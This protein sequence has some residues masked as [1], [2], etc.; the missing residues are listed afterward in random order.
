M[1][2]AVT[3]PILSSPARYALLHVLNELPVPRGMSLPPSRELRL[4]VER[5]EEAS[6]LLAPTIEERALQAFV[7]RYSTP[8][9]WQPPNAH[10]INTG[11]ITADWNYHVLPDQNP[12]VALAV[13]GMLRREGVEARV[14]GFPDSKLYGGAG[15][16]DTVYPVEPGHLFSNQHF[17]YRVALV[18]D[19]HFSDLAALDEL[20]AGEVTL[21]HAAGDGLVHLVEKEGETRPR[22]N[23]W[24]LQGD[25]LERLNLTSDIITG[26]PPTLPAN[27]PTFYFTGTR[28]RL[29]RVLNERGWHVPNAQDE[30]FSKI[31]TEQG[32]VPP[33]S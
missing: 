11:I 21:L 19:P 16:L 13:A 15:R 27:A 2:T 14:E 12:L 17:T 3:T 8:P 33:S 32:C 28:E 9:G 29:E 10:V 23:G 1:G 7:A 24:S 25:E 20:P 4:Y 18:H 5:E 26:Q 31:P 30:P 22:V 6:P